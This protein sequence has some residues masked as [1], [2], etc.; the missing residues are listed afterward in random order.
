MAYLIIGL[1]FLC[2]IFLVHIQP[3]LSNV[4]K[5]MRPTSFYEN[6]IDKILLIASLLSIIIRT[7]GIVLL[8]KSYL[9]IDKLQREFEEKLLIEKEKEE[10]KV[11]PVDSLSTSENDIL[12]V[13]ENV[14]RVVVKPFSQEYYKQ[15]LK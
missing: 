3:F 4:L 14:D 6:K 7:S 5:M 2:F 15:I 10:K 8:F 11:V 13:N 9:I 12:S 1:L